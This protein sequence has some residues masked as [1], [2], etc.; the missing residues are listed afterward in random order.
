MECKQTYLRCSAY[1]CAYMCVC[2]CIHIISVWKI[3]MV[4]LYHF[5]HCYHQVEVTETRVS[6][7][8]YSL[9]WAVKSTHWNTTFNLLPV[10]TNFSKVVVEVRYIFSLCL[11]LTDLKVLSVW[12]ELDYIFIRWQTGPVMWNSPDIPDQVHATILN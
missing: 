1:L 9:L 2:F 5:L 8:F 10:I 3:L 4:S 6:T 12:Y 7:N 11:D